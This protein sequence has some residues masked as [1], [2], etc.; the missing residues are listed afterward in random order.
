MNPTLSTPR[1]AVS[2]SGFSVNE[3][4]VCVAVLTIVASAAIKMTSSTKTSV[5]SA[6]LTSDVQKLNEVVS[7]YLA[8]GGT[9]TGT[10]PQ[11]VLDQ[12][13]TVTTTSQAA[14]NVGVMTGRGVDTRLTAEMQST[15]EINSGNARALWDST[16]KK[17][18]ISTAAGTQ[19]VSNFTFNN[20]LAANPVS[21]D[22]NRAQSNVTYNASVGWVWAP[23]AYSPAAFLDPVNQSL[24]DQEN[25]Y[26]PLLAGSGSGGG[27]GSTPSLPAPIITPPGG[28]FFPPQYPGAIFINPNGAPEGT[29][30]LKY[31]LNGGAWIIYNGPFSVPS[32]TKV[33]T[34]S[35]STNPEIYADSPAATSGF[36]ALVPSFTGDISARWN[37][38]EGPSGMVSHRYNSNPN[39]VE[40]TDGTPASGYNTGP[41]SFDFKRVPTF[42]GVPPNTDFR[43][44]TLLYHNGTIVSGT[45]ASVLHL[46]LEITMT[47][48]SIAETGTNVNIQLDNT[49]NTASAAESADYATLVNPTTNYSISVDGVTYTLQV[50]YGTISVSQGYVSG[51]T[52]AVWEGST[53]TVDVFGS[54]VSSTP[55]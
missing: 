49:I 1:H 21:Y 10:T 3:I 44:G 12:L 22:A 45:G 14:Q 41:N 52:L 25:K 2:R 13:K 15:S 20:A 43:L 23:G 24:L 7:V 5:Q 9:I 18:Y 31:Q 19:G 46:H 47:S 33:T 51:N 17:F 27:G 42:N 16:N 50:H 40:E 38:S 55:P 29:S 37:P 35:F 28:T 53:G 48:P 54:F 32:G 6:K 8:N 39:D 26:N 34:K 11:A 4:L 30:I 36:Y